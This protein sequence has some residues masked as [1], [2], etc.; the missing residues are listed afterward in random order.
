[1]TLETLI[2]R[3][4][5][6]G[7]SDIHLEAGLPMCFRIRGILKSSGEPVTGTTL[8][9]MARSVLSDAAWNEFLVRR[10]FDLAKTI[11]GVR[12]RINILH[13]ARGIGFAIRLLSNFRATI[14][15]LNL[16]PELGR[17]V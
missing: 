12:C 17:L 1:M 15:S 3:A 4:K 13:S 6:L 16:H 11:S 2:Q 14:K 5:T 8:N 7:A 9:S 10:S